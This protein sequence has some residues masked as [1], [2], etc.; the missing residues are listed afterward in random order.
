MNTETVW[1]MYMSILGFKIWKVA[2]NSMAPSAPK[3]SY[4]LVNHWFQLINLR[5]NSIV[6]INHHYYGEVLK[7]IAVIDKYGFIWSRS[8]NKKDELIEKMGP[9]NKSQIT[10]RVICIFKK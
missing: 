4:L 3:G 10:G 8:D 9:V 5:I 2:D 7:K 1:G 6:F